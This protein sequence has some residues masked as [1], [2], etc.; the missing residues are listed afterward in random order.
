MCSDKVRPSKEEWLEEAAQAYERAFGER[1]RKRGRPSTFVELEEAACEE[2]DRLTRWLL[3]KKIGCESESCNLGAQPCPY[4]GKLCEP[5]DRD[6]EER[7][8]ET[9]RGRV[10]FPRRSYECRP[11]RRM[12]FPSGP[13]A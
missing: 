6:E 10:S 1:D 5:R 9:R 7:E 8:I 13:P 4:C 12:F 11:C 3:E 2:G